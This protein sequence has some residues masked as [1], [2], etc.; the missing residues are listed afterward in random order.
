MR[1]VILSVCVKN[2][3]NLFCVCLA[4]VMS[5]AVL[6]CKQS[7]ILFM[8]SN[9]VAP[10]APQIPGHPSKIVAITD[11]SAHPDLN[12]RLYVTT[13]YTVWSYDGTTWKSMT[14][15]P[16]ASGD[17]SDITAAK[18]ALFVRTVDPYRLWKTSDGTNW[19]EIP[20]AA[21]SSYPKLVGI[22]A[23]GEEL[24]VAGL[25]PNDVSNPDYAI[26]WYDDK[27]TPDNS[28]DELVVL[29]EIVGSGG[30]LT[31]AVY[32]GNTF[33][34]ATLGGIYALS[35]GT[36]AE[37]ALDSADPLQGSTNKGYITGLIADI[38][39]TSLL[40]VTAQNNN[41]ARI[42]TAPA[43]G[44]ST[45]FTEKN[46]YDHIRLNGGMNIAENSS[47]DYILMVGYETENDNFNFGYR[48]IVLN[49][50]GSFPDS[51]YEFNVPGASV[52]TTI[53]Y[54]D[55]SQDQYE[56]SLGREIV[57]SII[58]TPLVIDPKK[59]IFA[60]TYINGLWSYRNNEWNAEE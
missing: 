49:A 2:K 8:I 57:T 52:K 13:K 10:K 44:L 1:N 3:K 17:I 37:G 54:S 5:F 48:E 28:D 15:Q 56:S 47:G 22:Y 31:G 9:E 51:G 4:L 6:S 21:A 53:A 16:P 11:A 29:K 43:A 35:D 18:D 32:I 39:Q 38:P 26:L 41:P 33:Y 20:N 60:S 14:H 34:L 27:N 19:I 36:L 46:Y 12:N 45:E 25:V 50:D 42:L 55:G 7:P 58:Q 30:R 40:A 24:F 23:A 59:T